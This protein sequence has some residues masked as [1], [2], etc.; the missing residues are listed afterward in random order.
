MLVL[1][2]AL[3]LCS[4]AWVVILPAKASLLSTKQQLLLKSRSF[5]SASRGLCH[6]LQSQKSLPLQ[7]LSL[8]SLGLPSE[9]QMMMSMLLALYRHVSLRTLTEF[10]RRDYLNLR[11]TQPRL[12]ET[13]NFQQTLHQ[14]DEPI[15]QS[16]EANK[17]TDKMSNA[18]SYRTLKLNQ[19]EPTDIELASYPE[20][21][22][23]RFDAGHKDGVFMP[24]PFDKM[25]ATV[26]G[27]VDEEPEDNMPTVYE[28][29]TSVNKDDEAQSNLDEQ[30][31]YD[32]EGNLL[33][34]QPLRIVD[35]GKGRAHAPPAGP[36]TRPA[37]P[38][39][40]AMPSRH[41]SHD[42]SEH[43]GMVVPYNRLETRPPT[44]DDLTRLDELSKHPRHYG[45][46]QQKAAL[47]RHHT[48]NFREPK[49][50]PAPIPTLLNGEPDPRIDPTTGKVLV[51]RVCNDARAD[52]D[53]LRRISGRNPVVEAIDEMRAGGSGP[54]TLS[55]DWLAAAG[56]KKTAP[57]PKKKAGMFGGGGGKKVAVAAADTSSEEN[58]AAELA[59]KKRFLEMMKPGGALSARLEEMYNDY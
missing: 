27:D 51:S 23:A 25:N 11:E 13:S 24:L 43:G 30:P 1:L 20:E 47:E 4:Q 40:S 57:E 42:A 50:R 5:L 56:E 36:P 18:S 45:K 21:E 59:R 58:K 35:K 55:T 9:L 38:L 33:P 37:T 34:A 31:Q 12:E 29:T 52:L 16:S 54:D 8:M 15:H 14:S 26:T 46:T 19:D 17:L 48:M 53:A 49:Q 10:R 2:T 44:P 32:E 7:L 39:T 6:S 41:G 28:V 22:Q 3:L